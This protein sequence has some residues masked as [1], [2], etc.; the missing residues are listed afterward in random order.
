MDD[1]NELI[2]VTIRLPL[3][4]KEQIDSLA[5]SGGCSTA[6]IIRRSVDGSLSKYLGEVQYMDR[7]QGESIKELVDSTYTELS[8]IRTELHRIGVNYNQEV[9]LQNLRMQLRTGKI[10]IPEASRM[11]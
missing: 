1:E 5:K 10:S 3:R 7:E 4:D 11:H 2:Q 6:E 8:D 9:R